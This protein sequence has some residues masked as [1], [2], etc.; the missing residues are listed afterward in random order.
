M[1]SERVSLKMRQLSY[2]PEVE[3]DSVTLLCI[4]EIL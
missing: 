4:C 1:Q 2:L 3:V